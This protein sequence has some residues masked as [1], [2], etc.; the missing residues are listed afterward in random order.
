M[1]KFVS[2]SDLTFKSYKASTLSHRRVDRA[3]GKKSYE[4]ADE[5]EDDNGNEN[6]DEDVNEDNE[7]HN[8]NGPLSQDQE[9]TILE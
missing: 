5:N 8:D 6:E 2:R 9:I 1:L 4:N 7:T 3:K